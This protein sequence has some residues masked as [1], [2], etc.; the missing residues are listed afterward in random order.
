MRVNKRL[1]VEEHD[2]QI[3][4]ENWPQAFCGYDQETRKHY[5]VTTDYVHASECK[6]T[7]KDYAEVFA[8]APK[9]LEAVRGLQNTLE[10]I[11]RQYEDKMKEHHKELI[12]NASIMAD[13]AIAKAEGDTDD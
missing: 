1:K 10:I 5:A 13:K 8:A 11:S 9:L 6:G 12:K 4:G 7:A 3:S 2:G